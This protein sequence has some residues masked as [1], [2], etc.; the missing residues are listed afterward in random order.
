MG[1]TVMGNSEKDFISKGIIRKVAKLYKIIIQLL[2][3]PIPC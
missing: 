3:V 1:Y 2:N